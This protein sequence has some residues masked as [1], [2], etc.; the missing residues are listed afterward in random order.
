MSKAT[1]TYSAWDRFMAAIAFAEAD[2]E[3]SAR[4]MVEAKLNEG[5][6]DIRCLLQHTCPDAG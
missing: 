2:D 1:N 4:E 5:E 6:G 3:K